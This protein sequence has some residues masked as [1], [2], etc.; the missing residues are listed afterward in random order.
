ME[1]LRR[2]IE[3][4]LKESPGCCCASLNSS[5]SSSLER[6]SGSSSGSFSEAGRR[7]RRA[8]LGVRLEAGGRGCL[9]PVEAFRS[10]VLAGDVGWL[11]RG[12]PSPEEP[13]AEFAFTWS[14]TNSSS[15]T[16]SRASGVEEAYLCMVSIRVEM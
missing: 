2:G 14:Q 13:L 15:A 9:S 7:R 3:G 4:S 8:P 10:F 1:E 11:A 12:W 6:S 5:S 16:S